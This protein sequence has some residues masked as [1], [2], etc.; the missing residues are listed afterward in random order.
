MRIISEFH[1][2]Y[3]IGMSE[4]QDQSLIY[5]RRSIVEKSNYPFN[6]MYNSWH[7]TNYIKVRPLTIGFCGKLYGLLELN[8]PYSDNCSKKDRSTCKWAYNL[9]DVDT[10]VRKNYPK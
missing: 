6:I 9:C 7:H 1:D 5:Q 4:G 10:Y 8:T 3:D 2:Y